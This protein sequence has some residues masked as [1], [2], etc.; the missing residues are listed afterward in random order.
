MLY[1]NIRCQLTNFD[2]NWSRLYNFDLNNYLMAKRCID[3]S[4]LF[5]SNFERTLGETLK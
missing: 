4:R 1:T 3:H 5:S 2:N